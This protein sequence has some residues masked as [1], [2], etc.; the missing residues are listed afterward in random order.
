[1]K[2]ET[3]HIAEFNISRL[4]AP[5]DSPVMREF[6]DFLAPV[7]RF[8]KESPGCIWRLAAPDGQAAS[9]LPPA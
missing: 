5:I 6:V 2:S 1:M 7:N 9:Y 8:A 3:F 4:K